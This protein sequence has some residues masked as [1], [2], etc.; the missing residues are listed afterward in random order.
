MNHANIISLCDPILGEAEKQAIVEV[1]E[2]QWITM[3]DRVAEF[4]KA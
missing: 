4:E 2:S 1:L 3:G